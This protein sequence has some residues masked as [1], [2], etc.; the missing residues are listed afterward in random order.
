MNTP[1]DHPLN[2]LKVILFSLVIVLPS[3]R[4]FF[5]IDQPYF[6]PLYV[7]L[8]YGI[9]FNVDKIIKL[10]IISLLWWMSFIVFI[11][12]LSFYL[13][14]ILSLRKNPGSTGDDAIILSAQTLLTTGKLY[15]VQ[16]DA[17]APISPGPAWI[18]V[19]SVFVLSNLYWLFAPVYIAM[20]IFLVRKVTNTV[21]ANIFCVLLSLSFNF[22][23]LLLNG[24]DLLPFAMGLFATDLMIHKFLKKDASLFSLIMISV[25]LGILASS[26]IVFGFLPVMY[27]LLLRNY[28]IKNSLILLLISTM[29]FFLFNVYYYS[30]NDF[31]QPAHLLSKGLR[32]VWMPVYI[33]IITSGIAAMFYLALREKSAKISWDW[34]V[35][36]ILS[37]FLLPIGYGDLLRINFDF[38]YWEGANYMIILTPFLLYNLVQKYRL[39]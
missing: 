36:L 37:S 19:N 26:R 7:L 22:V 12:V 31:Y 2:V 1:S 11:T 33:L 16:I 10:K 6:F 29:V 30:I 9:F 34:T 27:F 3:F 32:L 8:S 13:Y 38:K 21:V 17:S 28:H 35:F 20:A 14:P 39:V 18:L 4:L 5:K 25:C 23:E 15:D 24:H